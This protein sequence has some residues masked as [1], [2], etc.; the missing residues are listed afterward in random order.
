MTLIEYQILSER[1]FN[2]QGDKFIEVSK[3][4]VEMKN[5]KTTFVSIAKGHYFEGKK[6]YLK[7]TLN[8]PDNRLLINDIANYLRNLYKEEDAFLNIL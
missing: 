3:K 2:F 5:K 8:L 6:Q 1:T 4:I 7:G